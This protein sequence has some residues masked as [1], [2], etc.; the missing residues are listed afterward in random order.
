[1]C[2]L[3]MR[4]CV[5]RATPCYLSLIDLS[6]P[7]ITGGKCRQKSL[8][9]QTP[10]RKL[11]VVP[12]FGLILSTERHD[13]RT[14]LRIYAWA[15]CHGCHLWAHQVS[16]ADG[17]PS[18]NRMAELGGVG[19]TT[20]NVI[21]KANVTEFLQRVDKI[22][23]DD[24]K[25]A[26]KTDV[27]ELAKIKDELILPSLENL[28]ERVS[29]LTIQPNQQRS[30]NPFRGDGQATQTNPRPQSN[31]RCF[32]CGIPGHIAPQCSNQPLPP[33][34]QERTRIDRETP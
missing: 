20:G 27:G 32:R 9:Q 25:D 19:S 12:N 34:E 21:T 24:S 10:G 6:R 14:S 1:M 31:A 17:A 3:W 2:V 4:E 30:Q 28:A 13:G 16:S 18:P 23:E 22:V 8:S 26:M 33:N 15:G 5:R 7:A 29:K 11:V